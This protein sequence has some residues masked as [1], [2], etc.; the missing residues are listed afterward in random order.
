MK[1]Q[2]E[3]GGGGGGGKIELNL[4]RLDSLSFGLYPNYQLVEKNFKL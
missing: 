2:L 4:E 1:N 3:G